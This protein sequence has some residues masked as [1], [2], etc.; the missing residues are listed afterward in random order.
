MIEI[1]FSA[2]LLYS[3][4]LSKCTSKSVYGLC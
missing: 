3:G 2:I 4:S 1:A